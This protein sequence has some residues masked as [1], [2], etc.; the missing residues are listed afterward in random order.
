[1]TTSTASFLGTLIPKTIVCWRDGTIQK[2]FTKDLFS[3]IAVG[4]LALPLAMAFAIGSS[5]SPERGLFT[6][7][8]AGFLI[9]LLGGSRVQ[10]GGPTGAFIV[11]VYHTV[12]KHGYEGLVVATLLAGLFLIVVGLLRG[13]ILI[14]FIPHPVVTGFT[15]GIATVIFTGQ[16]KD[17]CGLQIPH[18]SA[19]FVESIVQYTT[20]FQTFNP[21]E[22]FIAA[23][24]LI[25]IL[26]CRKYIPKIPGAIVAVLITTIIALIFGLSIATIESKFGAIPQ[27]LPP[28]H[29]P[30]F[31]LAQIQAVFPEAVAIAVLGGIESLLSAV[32]AD[33]MTGFR[34]NSNM[35]LIAQGIANIASGLCGG[36]PATGAIART[37][38]NVQTGAK[39]PVAGIIHAL[40]LLVLMFLFAPLAGKIPIAALAAILVFTSW[41]MCAFEHCKDLF[42]GPKG[43]LVIFITT[44]LLTV[45]IDLAA[46]VQVGII[47]AALLFIKHI[48]DKT[49]LKACTLIAIEK[50]V[51][52][53]PLPEVAPNV[54]V[55][56]IEG[57]FFFAVTELLNDALTLRAPPPKIFILR[58]RS[59]PLIDA[60]GIQAIKNF[61]KRCSGHGILFLLCELPGHIHTLLSQN[62]V[63]ALIGEN[64]IF[65]HLKD[66]LQAA[67]LLSDASEQ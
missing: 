66:A 34:H 14:R 6:A 45:F 60:S 35:E 64:R 49:V 15:A 30:S 48:S 26:A 12:Q 65:S 56:E 43:D 20:H 53:S 7:V 55:F 29:L 61:Y 4:I 22:F 44:Y 27:S 33:G 32:I 9:S 11:L 3:G 21:L 18:P 51:P 38:T 13:G 41:R 19:E 2:N 24:A 23:I 54:E 40:T 63:L 47:L 46:A 17:F 31:S 16:I 10:I 57:P 25:I 5:L 58:L 37:T 39:T 62:G 8:I 1:M 59:V 67:A 52:V 36:I 50:E 28:P 42:R